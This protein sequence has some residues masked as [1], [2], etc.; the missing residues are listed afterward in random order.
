MEKNSNTIFFIKNSYI[1]RTRKWKLLTWIFPPQVACL[2]AKC[3]VCP[4]SEQQQQKLQ[5]LS[6]IPTD[7]IPINLHHILRTDTQ[8]R[9]FFSNTP[10][11]LNQYSKSSKRRPNFSKGSFSAKPVCSG[12]V[13]LLDAAASA[14]AHTRRSYFRF[15]LTPLSALASV[16]KSWQ[17]EDGNAITIITDNNNNNPQELLHKSSTSTSE[18][19]WVTLRYQLDNTTVSHAYVLCSLHTPCESCIINFITLDLK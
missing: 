18:C 13:R 19:E 9:N 6:N 10:Y 16:W 2:S 8:N 17:R 3:W 5:K 11:C 1:E 7:N 14:Y 12:C 4:E 15:R